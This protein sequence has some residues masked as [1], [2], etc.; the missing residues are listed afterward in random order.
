MREFI[1]RLSY[2]FQ[3]WKRERCGNYSAPDPTAP[4]NPLRFVAFVAVMSVIIG[5]AKPFVFHRAFDVVAIVN[6]SVAVVF[7]ALY[8]SNSRW[9]WHLVV[10]SMPVT[11]VLYWILRLAGYARYQPRV[12]SLTAEVIGVL[13]QVAFFAAVLVWLLYIR[14]RYFRY[15]ENAEQRT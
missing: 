14:D 6:I 11:L 3:L 8:Q 4:R 1:E 12:H 9:A 10:A 5:V 7:L 13:F 2:R 15:T